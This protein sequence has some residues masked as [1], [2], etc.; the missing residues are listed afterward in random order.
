MFAAPYHTTQAEFQKIFKDKGNRCRT[1]TALDLAQKVGTLSSSEREAFETKLPTT[2]LQN[3]LSLNM[4]SE[5]GEGSLQIDENRI[6]QIARTMAPTLIFDSKEKTPFPQEMTPYLFRLFKEELKIKNNKTPWH[7]IWEKHSPQDLAAFQAFLQDLT[8]NGEKPLSSDF[9]DPRLK[10]L[11]FPSDEPA[12]VYVNLIPGNEK[13]IIQYYFFFPRNDQNTYFQ[14]ISKA[15]SCFHR[16]F[17]SLQNL[18]YHD[19]DLESVWVYATKEETGTFRRRAVTYLGHG[20]N[21]IHLTEERKLTAPIYICEGS[22]ATRPYRGSDMLLDRCD[23]K[24]NIIRLANETQVHFEYISLHNML[25]D[26]RSFPVFLLQSVL[27]NSP[28]RAPKPPTQGRFWAC[29]PEHLEYL[30]LANRP[31]QAIIGKIWDKRY[32]REPNRFFSASLDLPLQRKPSMPQPKVLPLK[33]SPEDEYEGAAL[34]DRNEISEPLSNGRVRTQE[35]VSY[36]NG[37]R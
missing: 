5:Q 15:T 26:P 33:N 36:S 10:N 23:G 12:I 7:S 14:R 24:G 19:L 8:K 20:K 2:Y 1:S 18:S 11:K 22:H 3:L 29:L 21:A 28:Q 13:V 27:K 32:P 16:C 30:R 31:R 34:L 4:A 25:F 35:G 6:H 37:R 9:F 17:P